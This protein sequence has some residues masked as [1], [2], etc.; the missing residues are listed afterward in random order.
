[1]PPHEGDQY[2]ELPMYIKDADGEIH[3]IPRPLPEFGGT[4]ETGRLYVEG[5]D[6]TEMVIPFNPMDAIQRAINDGS[7]LP[8]TFKFTSKSIR[9][10]NRKIRNE[11]NHRKKLIRNIARK[12]EQFRRAVLKYG[13]TDNKAQLALLLYTVAIQRLMIWRE[14]AKHGYAKVPERSR[15]KQAEG[16][17]RR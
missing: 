16:A 4:I 17:G 12:K 2:G 14:E 5:D 1:M 6:Q 9:A 13:V 15:T 7:I 10:F 8:V 3:E 11:M